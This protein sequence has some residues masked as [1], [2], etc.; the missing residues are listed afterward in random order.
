MLSPAEPAVMLKTLQLGV[1]ALSACTF[2]RAQDAGKPRV[3]LGD[4]GTVVGVTDLEF[5][6][7]SFRGIPYAR[8]PLGQLRWREPAPLM[9]DPSRIIQATNWGPACIQVPFGQ[10]LVRLR[11]IVCISS[12]T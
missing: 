11:L 12:M 5:G 10:P 1:V 3:V 7:H 6:L 2:A 9:P 4:I 8:P